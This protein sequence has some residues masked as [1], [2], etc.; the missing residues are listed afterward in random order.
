MALFNTQLPASYTQPRMRL[1]QSSN[2]WTNAKLGISGSNKDGSSNVWGK[3]ANVGL[4]IGLGIVG[5]YFGGAAGAAA[6]SKLGTLA[7]R[8]MDAL[9]N[10]IM[11]GTDTQVQYQKVTDRQQS[12]DTLIQAAGGLLGNIASS[13]NVDTDIASADSA[14]VKA[15]KDATKPKFGNQLSSIQ[16]IFGTQD[17][18]SPAWAQIANQ[19]AGGGQMNST[20]NR[21]NQ[22][23]FQMN[24]ENTGLQT[25]II[26]D[27]TVGSSDVKFLDERKKTTAPSTLPYNQF[28]GFARGGLSV[29][30][31]FF[32]RGGDTFNGAY[33]ERNGLRVYTNNPK[34]APVEEPQVAQQ[35]MPDATFV[36]KAGSGADI[37]TRIAM[38]EGSFNKKNPYA[39]RNNIGPGHFGKYQLEPRLIF[40]FAPGLSIQQFME[41]PQAQ[42]AAMDRLLNQYK[43]EVR[44]IRKQTGTN[45]DDDSLTL[46]THFQGSPRGI[47]MLKNP[48]LLNKKTKN[49]P[50]V[51]D[52]IG[53]RS[54]G[55]FKNGSSVIPYKFFAEGSEVT[56]LTQNQI[57]GIRNHYY[58]EPDDVINSSSAEMVIMDG[59]NGNLPVDR[60]L[61]TG[62][63]SNQLFAQVINK[64]AGKYG[65]FNGTHRVRGAQV[66]SSA[67]GQDN[68]INQNPFVQGSVVRTKTN[69]SK[70]FPSITQND[71]IG[72]KVIPYAFFRSGGQSEGGAQGKK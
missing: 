71:R 56:P 37:K 45:W 7:N 19:L 44:N 8:G 12:D 14:G 21:A 2:W 29:P 54:F 49:N 6:G 41:S 5:G 25:S 33:E 59:I 61:F 4:P 34:P 11:E 23:M 46:L 27:T 60:S 36:S 18:G 16:K 15:A 17:N 65:S 43:S 40:K 3:I 35:M 53:K 58:L 38:A 26:P 50:S 55:V 66:G 70:R 68:H 62:V 32:E 39:E 63:K 72:S 1:F 28:T 10:N 30:F 48:D 22:D 31:A 52:Y 51:M 42:E 64:P 20:V 24:T 13:F 57:R 67:T 47:Q 69:N 9:G